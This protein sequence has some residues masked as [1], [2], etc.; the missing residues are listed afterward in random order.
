MA[1]RSHSM[2]S[3]C[4]VSPERTLA[5][6]IITVSL[7]VLLLS[8]FCQNGHRVWRTKDCSV[9]SIDSWWAEVNE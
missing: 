5:D 2:N 1:L 8:F 9:C 3:G 7:T 4:K 6:V